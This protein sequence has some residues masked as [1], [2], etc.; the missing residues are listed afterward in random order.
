LLLPTVFPFCGQ[1]SSFNEEAEKAHRRLKRCASFR[2]RSLGLGE[3]AL[4]D[5][6][7]NSPKYS[8]SPQM[9]T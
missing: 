4:S 5:I 3:L 8:K 1:R 7:K 9:I 6:N 2:R